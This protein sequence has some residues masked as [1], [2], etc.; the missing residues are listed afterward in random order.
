MIRNILLFFLIFVTCALTNCNC[1]SIRGV[2]NNSSH[3]KLGTDVATNDWL[4]AG[5]GVSFPSQNQVV[6][7]SSSS[8]SSQFGVILTQDAYNDDDIDFQVEYTQTDYPSQ[9]GYQSQIYLFFVPEGTSPDTLLQTDNNFGD[10]LAL[11]VGNI[12]SKMCTHP[13]AITMGRTSIR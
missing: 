10:F 11:T 2:V 1:N 8:S 5:N 12:K 9:T 13:Q 4:Y 7:E 3:R 6:L